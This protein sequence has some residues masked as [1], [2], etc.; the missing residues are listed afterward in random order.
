MT[1]HALFKWKKALILFCKWQEISEGGRLQETEWL[2][3]MWQQCNEISLIHHEYQFKR[4]RKTNVVHLAAKMVPI[5]TEAS[6]GFLFS[7]WS[8]LSEMIKRLSDF[9]VVETYQKGTLLVFLFFALVV[10]GLQFLWLTNKCINDGFKI[11]SSEPQQYTPKKKKNPEY[12]KILARQTK[13]FWP[14]FY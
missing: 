14:S 2:D 12:N 3:L 8:T 5:P 11:S 6:L 9:L 7:R 4:W 10:F 13:R 1:F